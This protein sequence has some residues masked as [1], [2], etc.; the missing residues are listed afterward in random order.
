MEGKGMDDNF[1]H[2]S[3]H[4][5]KRVEVYT[6]LLVLHGALGM[7]VRRMSDFLN[8]VANDFM[9]IQTAT[10]TPLGQP[11]SQSILPTPVL[12][13]RSQI[14]CIV[15][16]SATQVPG[17]TGTAY[18]TDVLGGREVY[19]QKS[20]Y[21]CYALTGSYVIRAHC[22]LHP[23]TTIENLLLGADAFVPLT[24]ATISVV[25]HPNAVWHREFIL[26][27]KSMLTCMYLV[28]EPQM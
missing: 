11:T 2:D 12:V 18:N 8:Q 9:A 24:N 25:N 6:D 27:N 21:P 26:L 1:S 15:E 4:T 14:N 13:R 22:F 5:F 3:T 10:I 7:T 19:V 20:I 28:P 17:E 16:L 23:G